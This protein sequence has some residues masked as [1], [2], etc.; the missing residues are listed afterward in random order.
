MNQTDAVRA[1]SFAAAIPEADRRRMVRSM[2][3]L[4]LWSNIWKLWGQAAF[5]F[6]L[7]ILAVSL[8]IGRG[9]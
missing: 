2:I 8:A 7:A 3:L 5:W 4:A 9:E 1:F 6:A